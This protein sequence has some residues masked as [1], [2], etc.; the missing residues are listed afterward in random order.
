MQVGAKSLTNSEA[1]AEG[2]PGALSPEAKPDAPARG[3]GGERDRSARDGL[4][5]RR[6][7]AGGAALGRERLGGERP[8]PRPWPLRRPG[9]GGSGEARAAVVAARQ[10]PAAHLAGAA[11]RPAGRLLGR[12][13]RHARRPA[14]GRSRTPRRA[15]LGTGADRDRPRRARPPPCPLRR[16]GLAARADGQRRAVARAL[17]R[18]RAD[19]ARRAR[20]RP[21]SFGVRGHRDERGSHLCFARVRPRR[22]GG[23][24]RPLR[25]AP[26]A[27]APLPARP[28]GGRSRADPGRATPHRRL[29]APPPVRCYRPQGAASGCS[30]V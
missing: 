11:C 27:A 18:L 30:P 9:A 16:A 12:A 4:A 3:F 6:G 29:L 21:R 24:C 23:R 17:R 26:P 14:D 20:L 7:G 5:G 2:G 10:P 15:R 22:L 28:G 8:D 13:G 25:P 1:G 19:P